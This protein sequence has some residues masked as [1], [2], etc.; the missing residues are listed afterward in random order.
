MNDEF[1]EIDTGMGEY[2]N[3]KPSNNKVIP[4]NKKQRIR[5]IH[6]RSTQ[7]RKE[8]ITRQTLYV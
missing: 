5:K 6:Y 4:T 1:C 8:A 2:Q 3:R 7:R